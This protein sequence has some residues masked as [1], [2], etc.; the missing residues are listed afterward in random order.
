MQACLKAVSQPRSS[1]D[2]G[3]TL[4]AFDYE[5]LF[6]FAGPCVLDKHIQSLE[7]VPDSRQFDFSGQ[8]MILWFT[9][10]VWDIP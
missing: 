6:R 5:L 8:M 10:S 9:C 7:N 3:R 4:E 2:G 1:V